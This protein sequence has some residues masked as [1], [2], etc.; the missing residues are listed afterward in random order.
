[1]IGLCFNQSISVLFAN[2]RT[3]S[4]RSYLLL[5]IFAT[6]LCWGAFVIVLYSVNP[7]LTNWI[8]FS[9][10]YLSL[11]LA[12]SGIASIIGFVVRFIGLRHELAINSVRAAFRQSFLF[13]GLIVI[14]LLLLA[15]NLFTWV[16]LI[17][18]IAGLSVL[19]YFLLSYTQNNI[20]HITY[21]TEQERYLQ[22]EAEEIDNGL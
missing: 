6:S 11:F 4:L 18:L 20:E 1:M 22:E 13:A 3:M 16:N 17:L 10:F 12:I 9:L 7:D 2:K 14:S 21:S 15:N 19:E 5:M 8:G